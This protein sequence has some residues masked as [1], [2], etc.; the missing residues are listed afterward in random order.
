MK[1]IYGELLGE[2]RFRKVY[3]YLPD[4]NYVVKVNKPYISKTDE[5]LHHDFNLYEYKN[6]LLLK[7]YNLDHWVAECFYLDGIFLMQ[8]VDKL[9]KGLHR[10]PTFFPERKTDNYGWLDDHIV[11]IDYPTLGTKNIKLVDKI[12]NYLKPLINEHC[13]LNYKVTKKI[14]VK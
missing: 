5:I 3:E 12:D 13:L 9:P 14:K 8:R 2:G 4:K 11:C 7:T 10:I 6:F 1:T